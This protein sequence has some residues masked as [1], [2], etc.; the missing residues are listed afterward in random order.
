MATCALTARATFLPDPGPTPVPP[1]GSATGAHRRVLITRPEPG[2]TETAARITALGL[3]PI[4]APLQDIQTLPAR[5][6]PPTAV[7]A[8][9]LTSRNAIAP[10]PP[11]YHGL[12][13]WAVGD[14]TAARARRAGFNNIRSA[15]GDAIALSALIAAEAR[16]ADGT[17]LLAT[18]AGL[19]APLCASLRQR[20]FRVIRRV[21]Y[22]TRPAASLPV[23]AS[24][25]LLDRQPASVLFFSAEAARLFGH[26]LQVAGIEDT[27]WCHEALA[28]SPA[29]GVAVQRHPWG[30]IHVAASPNQDAMLAL[31][32]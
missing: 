4:K 23:A 16:P 8:L 30:A 7:A 20:G 12:P 25:M 14:A 9:V 28:I 29:V 11:A 22:R 31:L 5:L 24:Q 21:T 18:G 6:P 13:T 17:L 2:A 15:G 10:I 27:V 32:R 19:G 26:L 1:L 3:I